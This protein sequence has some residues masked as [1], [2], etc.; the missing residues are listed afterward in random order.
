[1]MDMREV[2]LTMPL[3]VAASGCVRFG[4]GAPRDGG[5]DGDRAGTE[6]RRTD[7]IARDGKVEVIE[8]GA[9]TDPWGSPTGSGRVVRGGS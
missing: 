4:F 2:C 8:D 3:L 9:V 6:A 1:M 5:A 7:G